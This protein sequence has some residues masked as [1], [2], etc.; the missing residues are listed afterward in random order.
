MALTLKTGKLSEGMA[1]CTRCEFPPVG[2]KSGLCPVCTKKHEAA[3]AARP[4]GKRSAAGRGASVSSV[5]VGNHGDNLQPTTSYG[6]GYCCTFCDW[7]GFSVDL[8]ED[9]TGS[10]SVLCPECFS[11]VE[12][13]E[14]E[15]A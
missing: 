10:D 6:P 5:P 13:I 11:N 7:V 15:Q 12:L 1:L 2:A 9:C 14:V 4:V 3:E 8:V